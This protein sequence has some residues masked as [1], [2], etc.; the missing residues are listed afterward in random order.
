MATSNIIYSN[1]DTSFVLDKSVRSILSK[2]KQEEA[3]GER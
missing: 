1:V 2:L 3:S